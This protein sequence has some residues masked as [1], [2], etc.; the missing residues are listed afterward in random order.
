[1]HFKNTYSKRRNT[2]HIRN[3]TQAS[4]P[5]F[6]AMKLLPIL[7]PTPATLAQ[8]SILLYLKDYLLY[9]YKKRPVQTKA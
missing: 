1:M 7:I 2:H 9:A 6:T 3:Q 5:Y 8:L 4:T